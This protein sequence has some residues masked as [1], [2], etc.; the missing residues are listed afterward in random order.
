M[1][2]KRRRGIGLTPCWQI[3]RIERP[4][5]AMVT[6]INNHFL[7]A[8]PKRPFPRNNHPIQCVKNSFYRQLWQFLLCRNFSWRRTKTTKIFFSKNMS[9]MIE[10]LKSILQRA[11]IMP[12]HRWKASGNLII[13]HHCWIKPVQVFSAGVDLPWQASAQKYTSGLTVLRGYDRQ[14]AKNCSEMEQLQIRAY[15]RI[16]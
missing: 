5:G 8:S 4:I 16:S 13:C 12:A 6:V 15:Q 9:L 1:N 11:F 7:R 2:C 10:I 14:I 3:Y